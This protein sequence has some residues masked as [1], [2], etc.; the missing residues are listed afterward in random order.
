MSPEKHR[1]LCLPDQLPLPMQEA[2]ALS[3]LP[4]PLEL[5]PLLELTPLLQLQLLYLRLQLFWERR[6]ALVERPIAVKTWLISRAVD[7]AFAVAAVVAFVTA[8]A[9]HFLCAA[10]FCQ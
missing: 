6:I 9:S 3:V 5:K 2:L 7:A 4:E 8:S 1:L 10:P